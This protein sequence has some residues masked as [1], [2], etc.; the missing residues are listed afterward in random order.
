MP[1][2]PLLSICLPT[3]NARSFLAER[4]KTIMA[5]TLHDWELIVC[6]SYSADG[7]W[8]FLQSFA[9]D[10]R[11]RLH[12]V[13]K[14]GLYA[15]WN[16]CLRRARGS[17]IYI[18]T[19]DDTMSDDCLAKLHHALAVNPS[20]D[21]AVCDFDE[22]DFAGEMITKE[23]AWHRRF[24]GAKMFKEHVRPAFVDFI[25]TLVMGTPWYTMTSVMF[26]S[27]VL[28]RSGLFPTDL[29]FMA[30]NVWTARVAF[31]TPTAYVPQ[32]LATFRKHP[33]QASGRP[34]PPRVWWKSHLAFRALLNEVE[35]QVPEQWRRSPLW[36]KELLNIQLALIRQDLGLY[37]WKLKKTPFLFLKNLFIALQTQPLWT[38][39]HAAKI[40]PWKGEIDPVQTAKDLVN[41]YALNG[42]YFSP[43]C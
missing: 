4:M 42:T 33:T 24:Y 11:V 35:S 13:P 6:D 7:T 19:A 39:S 8:E 25:A 17:F 3:L 41:K 27:E 34:I 40:F 15:G 2:N 1:Q 43:E 16:E 21:V 28:K 30:D 29:H 37:R 9:G 5:Q 23:D 38:V 10:S 12:Q 18:A 26:R 31:S 14:E 36:K 20:V 22:I 32:R